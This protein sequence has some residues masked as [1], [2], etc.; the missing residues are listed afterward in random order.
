MSNRIKSSSFAVI[1]ENRETLTIDGHVEISNGYVKF[2]DIE[3]D[4]ELIIINSFIRWNNKEIKKIDNGSSIYSIDKSHPIEFKNCVFSKPIKISGYLGKSL[5][6]NLSSIDSITFEEINKFERDANQSKKENIEFKDCKYINNIEINNYIFFGKFYI[7]KQYNKEEK[8]QK[9]MPISKLFFKNI[10]FFGNFKLHNCDIK[11]FKLQDVDFM[12]NADFYLSKLDK[13]EE[14]PDDKEENNGESDI[15]KENKEIILELK[16]I[17]FYDLALFGEV[18]FEKFVR[19]KYV[20]FQGYSHFRKAIFKEGLD[21]EYANIEKEMNFF[22]ITISEPSNK[23]TKNI[24]TQETYRIIKYQLSKVGNIIDANKYHAKE[25]QEK[26]KNLKFFSK[27]FFDWWIFFFHFLSS[28]H[29][30]CWFCALFWITCVGAGTE[31]WILTHPM[32]NDTT[33]A[34]MSILDFVKEIF[35][36]MTI[37]SYSKLKEYPIVFF[38]NKISLGYLYYQFLT[39]VRKDTRK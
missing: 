27:D 35:R 16:G 32:S 38:F 19:F 11:D 20:T 24:T 25:L 28:N 14:K 37:T 8:S 5:Q 9:R 3:F 13:A 34:T 4:N 21:L 1:D 17:N 15:Q 6:F 18:I 31:V 10:V 33:S 12:K 36:Y 29:S 30:R 7:N 22:G 26:W 2:N 39:A 23:K